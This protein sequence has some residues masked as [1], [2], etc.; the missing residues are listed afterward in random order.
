MSSSRKSTPPESEAIRNPDVSAF[1]EI[2]LLHLP[3]EW[4]DPLR[5]LGIWLFAWSL[6]RWGIACEEPD[7]L[8]ISARR[9]GALAADLRSIRE[10]LESLSD[11]AG[12]TH[13][14]E[15]EYR[16]LRRAGK[17]AERLEPIESK[18]VE[19]A[20]DAIEAGRVS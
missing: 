6:E 1:R 12:D 14:E 4:R 9:T 3:P 5:Q 8:A 11:E 13:M 16:L 7:T 18:L 17:V 20:G 10:Q 19:I 2:A 15:A